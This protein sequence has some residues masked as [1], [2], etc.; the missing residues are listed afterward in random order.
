M[1]YLLDTNV[2][3]ESMKIRPAPQVTDWLGAR[4]PQQCFVS[5]L[6]LGEIRAGARAHADAARR[7]ILTDWLENTLAP[8]F[9]GRA[10]AIDAGVARRWG[11]LRASAPRPLPIVDSL[12]A[13]TALAHDL[14]VV[15]RDGAFAD[16]AGFSALQV[17]NPWMMD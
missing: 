7:N 13:A 9:A 2:L 1:R 5:V 17:V 3:S 4:D 10:L 16:I 11:D 14:T 15:S 8:W 6:T 12:L